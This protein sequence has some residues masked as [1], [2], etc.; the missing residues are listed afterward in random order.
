MP[1]KTPS[2]LTALRE[3]TRL[4]RVLQ[5]ALMAFLVLGL[6]PGALEAVE[7][8]EH[9]AH[10][11]HMPH[12]EEHDAVADAER[13]QVGDEHGCTPTQHHCQCCASL[14]ALTA[15]WPA[16]PSLPAAPLRGESHRYPAGDDRGPSRATSPPFRP[17]IG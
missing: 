12:S 3:P 14:A 7:V 5:W 11:G 6:T 4:L 17:P 16:S 8:V 13:H 2:L 15:A 10:D 1:I 9:L